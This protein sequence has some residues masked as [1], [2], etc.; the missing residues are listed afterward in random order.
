MPSDKL[1]TK[2]RA[3]LFALLAE[4]RE[5]SNTELKEHF[6]FALD[7][8]DRQKLND[9]K[10]VESHKEGRPYVHELTDAGWRWCH[11]EFFG[12]P[13]AGSGTLTRATYGVLALFGRYMDGSGMSL[14]DIH[15]ASGDG[16]ARQDNADAGVGKVA[17][18]DGDVEVGVVTAY[19]A[20]AGEPGEFVKLSALRGRLAGVSR[21]DADAALATMYR[22]RRINLIPQSD[23]LSLTDE[24]RESALRIGGEQ[25]HLISIER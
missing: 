2:Q 10:L 19:R 18:L 20:L 3:A 14:A 4:A 17:K 21:A 22:A 7:G 13:P 15:A 9:L 25:K 1:S 11:D 8:K 16:A 6:G 23:Q 24:D 5:V 12:E